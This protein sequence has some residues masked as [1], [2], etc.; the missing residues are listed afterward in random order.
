MQSELMKELVEKVINGNV[1]AYKELISLVERELYYIAKIKLCNDEDA[2]DAV[3]QCIYKAYVNIRKLREKEKFKPWIREILIN[4][5]KAIHN[6]NNKS[7]KLIEK[8]KTNNV[9]EFSERTI[10][11]VEEELDFNMLISKLNEKEQIALTLY[12]KY[13]CNTNDIGKILNE[14]PSTIKSRLNRAENKLK[15]MLKEGQNNE[16]NV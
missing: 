3:S 8:V 16:S 6:K 14:N 13:D 5:C 4:E 15:E 9:I 11:K 10:N 2:N 1:N 12:Y 7:N